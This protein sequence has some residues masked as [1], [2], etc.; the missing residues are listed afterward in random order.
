MARKFVNVL[1]TFGSSLRREEAPANPFSS[2]NQ[3]PP[4]A[5]DQNLSVL[6]RVLAMKIRTN[7]E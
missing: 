6:L 1:E 7:T 4:V 3:A 5:P 2:I